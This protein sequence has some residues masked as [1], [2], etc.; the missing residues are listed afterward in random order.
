MFDGPPDIVLTLYTRPGCHLC[1][2]ARTQL[3]QELGRLPRGRRRIDVAE[4]D[5]DIDGSLRARYGEWIPVLAAGDRE[6]PLAMR[7]GTIA[8]FLHDV[9]DG[10]LAPRSG[11][12]PA[13]DAPGTP[14]SGTA[15]ARSLRRHA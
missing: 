4:V 12:L 1:D 11:P 15:P 7:P 8:A 2:D 6:L 9:F 10:G 3:H 5:I 13:A 14:V